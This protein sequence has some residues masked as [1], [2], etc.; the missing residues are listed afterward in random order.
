MIDCD[1]LHCNDTI[2]RCDDCPQDL[3]QWVGTGGGVMTRQGLCNHGFWL[4]DCALCAKDSGEC[5]WGSCTAPAT[6]VVDLERERRRACA[7]HAPEMKRPDLAERA[8]W[9]FRDEYARVFP[10]GGDAQDHEEATRSGIGAVL[11]FASREQQ[12]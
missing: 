10:S 3:R 8:Y 5:D 11:A 12:K 2:G 9:A 4:K 7:R 1:R 6:G